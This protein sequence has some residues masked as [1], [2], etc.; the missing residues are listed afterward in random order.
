MRE[1]EEYRPGRFR[2]RYGTK[3]GL[4]TKVYTKRVNGCVQNPTCR[5]SYVAL[6]YNSHISFIYETTVVW[7]DVIPS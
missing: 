3:V 6:C 5:I 1:A 4:P 7:A 2:Y